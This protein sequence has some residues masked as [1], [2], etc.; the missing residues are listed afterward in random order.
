LVPKD[1][2]LIDEATRR[3]LS[4]EGEPLVDSKLEPS[5][6]RLGSVV[7]PSTPALQP[8]DAVS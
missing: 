7:D 5:E 4:Q 6:E 8:S 2:A 3:G 1:D